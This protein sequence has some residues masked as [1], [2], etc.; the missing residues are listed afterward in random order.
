[1]DYYFESNIDSVKTS[2]SKRA[3]AF[4]EIFEWLDAIVISVIA[5]ILLFT[6]VFRTVGIKGES[7]ENTLFEN[8]HV[9]ISN[10]FYTP[11]QGDI[12]VISRNYANLNGDTNEDDSPIIKRVIAVAGQDVT[13]DPKTGHVMVDNMLISENYI[14][15]GAITTWGDGSTEAK[16]IT[17]EEGKIFVMGDNREASLD[18]RYSQIGQVDIRYVLGRAIFRIY[19]LSSIGGL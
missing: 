4:K 15:P 11:K 17:V 9:V 12:V 6:F 13:I 3:P 2:T 19:P 1:M 14:K 16:T 10:L 7:M 18:S 8:D 5:V